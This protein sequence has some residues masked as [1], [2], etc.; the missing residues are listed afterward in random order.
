MQTHSTGQMAA[1][2]GKE[3]KIIRKMLV[4]S[5]FFCCG[6]DHTPCSFSDAQ[7]LFYFKFLDLTTPHVCSVMRKKKF[8]LF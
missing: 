4:K 3:A 7:F 5:F 6:L 1:A 2:E 8:F